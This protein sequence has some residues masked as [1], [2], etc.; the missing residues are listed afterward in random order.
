VTGL[1]LMDSG[2]GL[3]CDAEPAVHLGISSAAVERNRTG[4]A[5]EVQC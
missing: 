4:S 1:H 2:Y 3:D 5:V